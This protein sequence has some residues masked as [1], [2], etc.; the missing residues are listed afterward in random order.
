M[1]SGKLTATEIMM[2]MEA[3]GRIRI[4]RSRTEIGLERHSQL[5][6]TMKNEDFLLRKL[7]LRSAAK[8]DV[9]MICFNGQCWTRNIAEW[10]SQL[11]GSKSKAL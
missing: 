3:L 8:L 11:V 2:P 1:V 9:G 4:I 6:K 10:G 5:A 7:F